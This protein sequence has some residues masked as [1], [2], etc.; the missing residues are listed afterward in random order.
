MKSIALSF[1][2]M[3]ALATPAQ[4]IINADG[5][6]QTYLPGSMYPAV[7]VT[8]SNE[9]AAIPTAIVA[10]FGTNTDNVIWC[11]RVNSIK[12][13]GFEE[14]TNHIEFGFDESTGMK[15][16]EINGSM[17][18][19]R[20]EGKFLFSE[21]D[22]SSDLKYLRIDSATTRR[23]LREMSASELCSNL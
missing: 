17:V 19:G 11:A 21:I 14:D 13:H 9:E 1:G 18:D 3:L 16:I 4:A 5:C 2:L 6:Y 12:V 22:S 20:E 23:L 10:I 15:S 7:C 8:G